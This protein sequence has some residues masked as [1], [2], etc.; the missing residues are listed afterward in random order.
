MEQV[1]VQKIICR[2]V[3]A[4]LDGDRVLGEV[5]G[6]VVD[7]FDP[8]GL[9]ELW[10]VAAQETAATNEQLKAAARKGRRGPK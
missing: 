7:C 6:P 8:E 2:V 1:R 9:L 5:V 10:Q 3:Q 4:R